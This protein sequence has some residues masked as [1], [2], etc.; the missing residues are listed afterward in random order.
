MPP[1]A[2]LLLFKHFW[3]AFILMTF[4]N[5]AIMWRQA[6]V[7]RERDPSLVEGYR[8]LIRGFVTWN[9]I[10]W[11]VMGAGI[12]LGGV[13]STFHYFDPMYPSPFVAAFFA[14]TFVLW[15]AGSYWLFARGGAEQIVRHPGLV[16]PW[17]NSPA[18]IKIL[19]LLCLAGGVVGASAMFLVRPQPPAFL[20]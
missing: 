18:R 5:G 12:L 6:S 7:Y 9:N 10:P 1:P 4:L 8:S 2:V 13:P 3:A 20:E 15:A 19:W 16:Q 17:L 14:S 11:A